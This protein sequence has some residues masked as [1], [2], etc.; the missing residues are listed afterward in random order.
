M[1]DVAAM[2]FEN[3]LGVTWR[4]ALPSLGPEFRDRAEELLS[5]ASLALMAGVFIGWGA[6]HA[7]GVGEIV[8]VVIGA[9]GVFSIGMARRRRC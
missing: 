3:R 5:P 2:S 8:D 4:R 1:A 9:V 6:S 7:F